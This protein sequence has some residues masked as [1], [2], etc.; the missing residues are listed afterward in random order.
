MIITSEGRCQQASPS[1]LLKLHVNFGQSAEIRRAIA[2]LLFRPWSRIAVW[3][4][5][6]L[7]LCLPDRFLLDARLIHFPAKLPIF[8]LPSCLCN[9]I[10]RTRRSTRL[11][12]SEPFA[13]SIT[14]LEISIPS[15]VK[16]CS[17]ITLSNG[18]RCPVPAACG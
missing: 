3:I 5:G 12:S 7:R 17:H 11:H 8:S 15:T 10:C 18:S 9:A 6:S 4:G 1:P 16:P 2:Q 13:C 14:L